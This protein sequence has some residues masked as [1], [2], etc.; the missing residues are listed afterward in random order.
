M[1]LPRSIPITVRWLTPVLSRIGSIRS[2]SGG[3]DKIDAKVVSHGRY[4]TFQMVEIAVS[5]RVFAEILSL[6]ARLRAS[7]ESA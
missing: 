4:V 6:I 1:F 7:P 2:P 3:A 5:E